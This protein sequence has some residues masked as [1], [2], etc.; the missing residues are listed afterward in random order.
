MKRLLPRIAGL[1]VGLYVFLLRITCRIRVHNDM[2][3]QL[4]ADGHRY[5]CGTFHAHQIGGLM[6]AE[7]GTGAIVSRSA[8]GEIVVPVLVWSGHVPIRGSSGPGHKG[9]ATALQCLIKH[10]LKGHSAML[11]VDGPRG[12]RGSVH[13]GIGLLAE[14]T[15]AAVLMAVAVPSKRWIFRKTWDRFQLPRLFSRI[16]LYLSDPLFTKAGESL[17]RFTERIE[18]VLRE[19]EE[20]YDPDE[21]ATRRRAVTRPAEGRPIG[22]LA[23]LLGV[24]M[25]AW[26]KVDPASNDPPGGHRRSALL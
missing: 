17:E 7:P 26:G 15:N 10:V 2:R 23:I 24:G 20:R 3:G 1:I 21:V 12:P 22:R 25:C 18:G 6:A 4:A 11:A 19:L 13:K 9:G 16:D 14:K 8:D 5:V